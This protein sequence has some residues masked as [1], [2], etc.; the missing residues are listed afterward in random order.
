MAPRFRALGLTDIGRVREE[1]QDRFLIDEARGL[2]LV[3]DGM[4][5]MYNGAEAASFVVK[6]LPALLIKN[7]ATW[8]PVPA[9]TLKRTI[10]SIHETG[11]QLRAEIGDHSGTTIT[12]A[13]LVD[14]ALV[15]ANL[16]DSPAY[17]LRGG[18]LKMLS[19]DHNLAGILV[20]KGVLT[21]NQALTHPGRHELTAYLGM[22][23]PAPV[24]GT[25]IIWETGDRLLLCTDGLS[26]LVRQ[27]EITGALTARP[28]EA[29][30]QALLDLANEAGGL[31]NITVVLVELGSD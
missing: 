28:L 11:R 23:E 13:V 29:A 30:A 31:D 27:S 16:G 8:P 26:G 14:R 25:E 21:P 3:A 17:L 1:N 19:R 5:G 7:S 22:P 15:V 24:H 18:R 20:E 12:V 4:G 9:S 10:A 2:F 6:E